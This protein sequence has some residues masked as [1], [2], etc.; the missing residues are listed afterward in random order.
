MEQR[1]FGP[2][3]LRRL[4]TYLAPHRRGLLPLLLALITFRVSLESSQDYT[5]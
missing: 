4:L 2:Q 3:S 1:L 5:E